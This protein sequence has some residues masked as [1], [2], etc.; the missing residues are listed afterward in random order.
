M[1]CISIIST[2]LPPQSTRHLIPEVG[3]PWARMMIQVQTL[4]GLVGCCL[5]PGLDPEGAE[6]LRRLQTLEG[7]D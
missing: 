1:Y 4:Q 6:E 3:D 5:G 7:H 2:S